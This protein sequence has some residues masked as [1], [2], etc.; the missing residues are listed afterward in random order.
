MKHKQ[1]KVAQFKALDEAQG[2]FEAI[3]A[4][5]GNVDRGGDRIMP[6]A[7][8]GSLKRWEESGDPI[9]IIF[10]H[11]WDNLDAHIGY[12]LEAKEV[13]EGLYVK[14]QIDMDEDY[15]RRVFKKMQ[16]RTLKQFSFA[17]DV[18]EAKEVGDADRAAP[19]HYQDLLELDLMEVG[20]CLVGMN[21]DTELLTVKRWLERKAGARHTSKEYEQIQQI[22]DLAVGLGAKCSSAEDDG[23]DGEG[24][25]E[26]EAGSGDAAGKSSGPRAS[27]VAQRVAL[28]LIE[29][30]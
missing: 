16:Q 20:P 22:H 14:G 25:T 24:E 7:F 15:A 28:E 26:D 2:Q 18:L 11:E 27:I 4:V 1:F 9:P 5:F 29:S 21:P 8:A 10:S 19:N 17:Y 6:G 30:V 12:T 3:V 13:D 23:G